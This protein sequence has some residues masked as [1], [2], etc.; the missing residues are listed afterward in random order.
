MGPPRERSNKLSINSS[1]ESS[2]YSKSSDDEYAHRMKIQSSDLN[3]TNQADAKIFY[4]P[5]SSQAREESNNQAQANLN[6]NGP[7]THVDLTNTSCL[8]QDVN[9]LSPHALSYEELQLANNN[10]WDS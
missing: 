8:S 1:K 4:I 5:L 9:R 2:A 10:S 6:L 7:T 3:W